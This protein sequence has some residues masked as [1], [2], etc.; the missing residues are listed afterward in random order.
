MLTPER[1]ARV[2][3]RGKQGALVVNVERGSVADRADLAPGDVIVE[4]D[5]RAVQTPADVDAALADG[6]ALLRVLRRDSALYVV[7]SRDN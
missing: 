6:T 7:L 5:R 2:G 3:Y 1:A 4:A